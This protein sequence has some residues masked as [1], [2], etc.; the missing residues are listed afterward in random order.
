MKNSN[1]IL[2]VII[3]CA[4]YFFAISAISHSSVSSSYEDYQP[5]EQKQHHA[6]ISNGIFYHDSQLESSVKGFDDFPPQNLKNFFNGSFVTK[7]IERVLE[8]QFTQYRCFS[9]NFLIQYRKS[10]IIFPFHYFW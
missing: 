5:T 2:G 9:I 3:L 7:S 1:R 4:I 6:K 8:V 10:D